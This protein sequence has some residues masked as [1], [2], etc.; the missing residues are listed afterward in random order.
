MRSV[1]IAG[2]DGKR[3]QALL[4]TF[5]SY[6]DAPLAIP[7]G[8]HERDDLV[9]D[10]LQIGDRPWIDSP[11]PEAAG[12]VVVFLAGFD[13]RES[14]RFIDQTRGMFGPD[15]IFAG[16]TATNATWPLARLVAELVA[17]RLEFKKRS[18]AG[19]SSQECAP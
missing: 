13:G 16:L 18:A 12:S 19:E 17:E 8:N 11:L 14:S 4:A 7:V 9:K 6:E 3:W 5:S 2:L 10:L 1:L 15:V